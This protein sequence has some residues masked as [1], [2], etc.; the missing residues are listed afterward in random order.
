MERALTLADEWASHGSVLFVTVDAQVAA[1]L[2]MA[3]ALKPEAA[4]TVDALKA[5]GVRPVLLTGDK[6]TSGSASR[7]QVRCAICPVLSGRRGV[8][9]L[10]SWCLGVLPCCCFHCANVLLGLLLCSSGWC[11]TMPETGR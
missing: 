1:V 4:K 5:L 6:M 11:R 8:A 10:A 9:V 2:L 3:D 7:E